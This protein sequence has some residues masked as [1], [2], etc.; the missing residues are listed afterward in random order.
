MLMET[1]SAV[2]AKSESYPQ[3]FFAFPD[4]VFDYVCAECT[5]LCCKGHGFGGSFERELRVLFAR[6]PQMETMALSRN[7]DQITLATTGS[8][9]VMLDNDNFCRIEKELG[10]D[11]KPNICNLFP[12]NL[13]TRIGK[14]VAVMPHFLCPLR[15]VVPA[16]PGE[17]QGTHALIEAEIRKSRLLDRTYVKTAVQ[18]A[19][20]HSSTT[21]IEVIER[22]KAFRDLCS[23]ALGMSRFTDTLM[24][25]SADPQGLAAFVQRARRILGYESAPRSLERDIFDDLLLAC[26]APYR[27]GFLDLA[28]EEILRVLAIAE[29]IVRRAWF[30]ATQI[31]TFQGLANTVASFRAVEALLAYGDE[32]FDFGRLTQK[33]F[34]F[35]NAELT[36]AAFI[37]ARNVAEKGVLGALEQAIPSGMSVADR[38]VLLMR[39]G[40]L[41]QTT[42]SKRTR[43]HGATVDKILSL[44]DS[45]QGQ[46][47]ASVPS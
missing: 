28:A 19:R 18:P 10:K 30:G 32:D 44:Q 29:T 11:K 20:L 24:S 46:A 41:M 40:E 42:K 23:Q 34:S 38:S 2:S 36:F 16:R 45:G 5:A 7:G 27:I 21:E 25:A 13:F 31:P 12:F 8:G 33:T 6:Y 39:L 4:G 35:Q 9:C 1:T 15:A 14:T 43:K 37:A 3:L 17:V 47:L 26:A 22:E